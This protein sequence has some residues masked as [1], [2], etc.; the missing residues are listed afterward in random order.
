[1]V[2]IVV[3]FF[4]EGG[5]RSVPEVPVVGLDRAEYAEFLA[6]FQRMVQAY[7]PPLECDRVSVLVINEKGE[8]AEDLSGLTLHLYR[9]EQMA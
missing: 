7:G 6:E 8:P 5:W 3:L 4:A 9:A 2:W 1:M